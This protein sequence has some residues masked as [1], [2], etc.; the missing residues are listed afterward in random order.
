MFFGRSDLCPLSFA[1]SFVNEQSTLC[2]GASDDSAVFTT[3][4]CPHDVRW[5]CGLSTT[6]DNEAL[7]RGG[8]DIF[9]VGRQA[10]VDR[11]GV[12]WGTEERAIFIDV[13]VLTVRELEILALSGGMAQSNRSWIGVFHVAYLGH[14]WHAGSVGICRIGNILYNRSPVLQ[15]SWDL[16]NHCLSVGCIIPLIRVITNQLALAVNG[17][18]ELSQGTIE[19]HTGRVRMAPIQESVHY[20]AAPLLRQQYG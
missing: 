18:S 6:W 4:W 12:A 3:V 11:E 10:V 19:K 7:T 1:K 8:G 16:V 17:V 2:T 9:G 20:L 5:G 15:I 13:E 14:H